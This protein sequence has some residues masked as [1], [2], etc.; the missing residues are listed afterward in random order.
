MTTSPS[1]T[2]RA[3]WPWWLPWAAM[4]IIVVIALAVGVSRDDG[5]E[6]AQDRVTALA[7]QIKCPTCN[8]ESAADS[9]APGSKA[10]RI[11]L[12]ELIAQGQTDDQILASYPARFGDDILMTPS[13]SGLI[14]LVWILPVVFVGLAIAGLVL[15]FVRWRN[16]P[17][18]H[19][20]DDDRDLVAAARRD[21]DDAG[22]GTG[23]GPST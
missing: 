18:M 7:R 20:T 23:D 1:G 10:I 4:A 3:G 13:S 14:G 11:E 15:A 9:N 19:A 12:A 5:P 21:G 16:Q 22:S 6:T 17:T 2:R 8:G